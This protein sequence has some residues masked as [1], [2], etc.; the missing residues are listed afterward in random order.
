MPKKLMKSQKKRAAPWPAPKRGKARSNMKSVNYKRCPNVKKVPYAR[1]T[2]LVPKVDRRYQQLGHSV[3]ELAGMKKGSSL[4]RFFAKM[5]SCLDGKVG[6]VLDVH[7]ALSVPCISASW[8]RSGYIDAL[9]GPV[10]PSSNPTPSIPSSTM[11]LH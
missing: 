3:Q 10:M 2:T 7:M 1:H 6:H 11:A 9:P 8:G 5:A 4:L